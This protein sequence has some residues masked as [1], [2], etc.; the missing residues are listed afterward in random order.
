LKVENLENVLSFRLDGDVSLDDK[1]KSR[2]FYD[3]VNGIVFMS[4]FHVF[5]ES[6]VALL[7]IL[8]RKYQNTLTAV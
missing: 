3:E 5:V 7:Y 6:L 1:I 4:I 8:R 2:N